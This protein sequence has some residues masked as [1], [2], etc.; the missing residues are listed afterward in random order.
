MNTDNMSIHGLTID[1]GPYGWLEDYDPDWT[2]N[3]TDA[4]QR[5]Y[6]FGQQPQV[7][8]WN[9]VQLANALYPL[10]EDPE[11]LQAAIDAFPDRYSVHYQSM[12]AAKLGLDEWNPT[13]D[14][15]IVTELI[16][17]LQAVE[18]DMTIFFRELARVDIHST[19]ELGTLA[20]AYYR[21]EQL[22]DA[23]M[24]RLDEWI[25]RYA[26][27]VTGAGIDEDTRRAVMNATN[28][29]FVLRN[30]LAQLAIDDAENG[31]FARIEE[32]LDT[33]R[34]PYTD[35]PGRDHL[36][37]RRPEWARERAGCSQ[38]SCSS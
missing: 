27:R 16:G 28:P 30:Y 29:R 34:H 33:L 19:R 25:S 14:E 31:D 15:A 36:G 17:I 26:A 22:D 1:Y 6:R 8:H 4:G 3:T 11:P 38:L 20:D 18:T 37:E 21:P 13:T 24:L 32:L 7:A 12:M 9:L 10:V 2:P 35:Q 23:Y 5:R